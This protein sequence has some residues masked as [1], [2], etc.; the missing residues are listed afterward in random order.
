MKEQDSPRGADAISAA[1]Q[2]HL[3]NFH[4][5]GAELIMGSA[6]LTGPKTVS[7]ALNDGG[8]RVLTADRLFLNLGTRAAIPQVP[9]LAAAD[10]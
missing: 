10:Q 3:N 7:V 5:S 1:A 2:H 8:D 9:G 4:T 6:R